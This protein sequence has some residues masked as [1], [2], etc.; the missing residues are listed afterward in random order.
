MYNGCKVV[1]RGGK[2]AGVIWN[3]GRPDVVSILSND[4]PLTL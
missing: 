2:F 1:E 4:C 3:D